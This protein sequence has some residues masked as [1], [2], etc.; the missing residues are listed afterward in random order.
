MGNQYDALLRWEAVLHA[1]WR[2]AILRL[3]FVYKRVTPVTGS[4]PAELSRRSRFLAAFVGAGLLAALLLASQ[5]RPDPR[6]WG[7]HEQLGLP[8]CTLL[9]LTGTRC[10]ACGMTTSWAH[11]THGR[12][13]DALRVSATGT[14]LAGVA[15]VV[16]VTASVV[17]VRGRQV[18]WQPRE[19][20]VAVAA[21]AL[22]GVILFEWAVRLL[23]G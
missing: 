18:A 4:K 16:G 2:L 17:A 12:L 22:A 20:Q 3:P 23:R 1:R 9:A 6:G 8:P 7:T 15:F 19:T 13:A 14:L 5:L 10:P 11:F 21:L